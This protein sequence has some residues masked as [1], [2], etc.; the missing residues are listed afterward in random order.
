MLHVIKHRLTYDRIA[1]EKTLLHLAHDAE[2]LIVNELTYVPQYPPG[3]V[4]FPE[5]DYRE[6]SQIRAPQQLRLM[7]AA[8]I[9][10]P[11]ITNDKM[12]LSIILSRLPGLEFTFAKINK[13]QQQLTSK[14][15]Q[16]HGNS[17]NKYQQM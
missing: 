12:Y 4:D 9:L 16:K 10:A 1:N 11:E 8:A 2:K 7:A 3:Q 6:D 5:L 14:L 17:K 13:A 15:N